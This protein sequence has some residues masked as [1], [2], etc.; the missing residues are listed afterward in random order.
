MID[1]FPAP[2]PPSFFIWHFSLVISW[3]SFRGA[4]CYLVDR[5]L[6]RQMRTIH[7]ITRSRHEQEVNSGK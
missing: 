2:W 1:A 4:S 5:L 3:I 6:G 7:E